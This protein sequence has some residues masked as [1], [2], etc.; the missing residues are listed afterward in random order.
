MIE[1][2]KLVSVIIPVFNGERFLAEAIDSVFSQTYRRVDVV[3]V[4]DGSTDG[5]KTIAGRYNEL[6]Y[7]HQPNQGISVALNTGI[8]LAHGD[9]LAFLDAD[10][11]WTKDKLTLQMAAFNQNPNLDMIFGHHRRFCSPE[12]IEDLK[13]PEYN[14]NETLPGLLKGTM[15]IRRESFLKVGPFDIRWKMGDFIDWYS[16][17]Q[18]MGLSSLMLPEILMMRR[19]H[20]EN[21][22]RLNRSGKT[23][24]ARILKAALD[25]RRQT[26][27]G[28]GTPQKNGSDVTR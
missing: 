22:T 9:Y 12:L 28:A 4:D 25:R 17:A 10:D 6:R 20:A 5:S 16:R 11:L 18:E 2:Q 15:L 19:V 1:N 14:L 24:Y 13:G 27:A 26:D 7:A 23:D 8:E 21:T 3:M